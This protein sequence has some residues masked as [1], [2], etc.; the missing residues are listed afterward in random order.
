MDSVQVRDRRQAGWCWI[1][2]TI[3]DNYGETL[4]AYGL[5]VYLSLARWADNNNGQCWPRVATIA[6]RC[7][8]SESTVRRAIERLERLDLIEV[9]DV[10]EANGAQGANVY[11]LLA[12]GPGPAP[13]PVS[14]RTLTAA[15]GSRAE[16]SVALTR[17]AA[18][19]GWATITRVLV[20]GWTTPP[21]RASAQ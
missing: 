11:V 5:A 3:I 7:G 4:E 20:M 2:N 8:I 12:P 17:L 21:P 16:S 10:I 9:V 15:D 19:S 1:N 13:L 14:T 18:R 6:A